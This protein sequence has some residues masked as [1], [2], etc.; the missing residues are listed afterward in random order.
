MFSRREGSLY[1]L[2]RS[3]GYR[4]CL[5][6]LC[7]L[8]ALLN[9]ICHDRLKDASLNIRLSP[10]ISEEYENAASSTFTSPFRSE[11]EKML[12]QACVRRGL[13]GI[14]LKHNRKAGGSTITKMIKNTACQGKGKGAN[15]NG[16]WVPTFHSEL[17]YFNYSHAF[18]RHVPSLVYVTSLRHPVDRILSMYWF[19][20]RWPRTCGAPCENQKKKTN[21]TAVGSLDQWVDAILNQKDT[22]GRDWRLTLHNNCGIWQGVDNYYIRQFLG[23]DRDVRRKRVPRKRSDGRFHDFDI[24]PN[25]RNA[26]VTQSHLELAKSV[27]ASFDLVVILEELDTNKEMQRMLFEITS[28]NLANQNGATAS[29]PAPLRERE[30]TERKKSDYFPPT[31]TELNRLKN[32]NA[33]DIELYEYAK[34]LSNYTVQKWLKRMNMKHNSSFMHSDEY[35]LAKCTK[36]PKELEGQ[37]F[38]ILLGGNGCGLGQYYYRGNNCFWS[39][40]LTVGGDWR[41]RAIQRDETITKEEILTQGQ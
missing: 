41:Q 21:E 17:P 11:S 19:E 27:L 37:T 31:S 6:L 4:S 23:I 28:V 9:Y 5:C 22:P 12:A 32:L 33:L 26:T 10:F 14:Y 35:L 30:G 1:F 2:P 7:T 25:Y 34:Q 15:R 18:G 36:P 16:A 24:L 3:F 20:G 8:P 13:G 38:E 40:S 29:I 39:S